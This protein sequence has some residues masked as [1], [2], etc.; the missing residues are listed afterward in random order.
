M[1]EKR[2]SFREQLLA[3]QCAAKTLDRPALWDAVR[4]LT[5]VH[6][7][8]ECLQVAEDE[9]KVQEILERLFVRS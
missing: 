1:A 8:D 4:T 7:L 5:E 6:R 9:E 2:T 3:V